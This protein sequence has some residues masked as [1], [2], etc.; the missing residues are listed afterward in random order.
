VLSLLPRTQW[1]DTVTEQMEGQ[2]R[3]AEAIGYMVSHDEVIPHLHSVAVPLP[4]RGH[5]PAAIA[6]V[7]LGDQRRAPQLAARLQQAADAIRASIG[8]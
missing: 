1:P 8:G 2:L 3:E 6:V 4:L 7:S 5:A